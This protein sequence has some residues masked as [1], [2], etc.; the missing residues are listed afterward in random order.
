[1]AVDNKAT[2]SQANKRPE[3]TSSERLY[4]AFKHG[5][6]DRLPMIDSYWSETIER[7]RSEGLPA[8]TSLED[9]RRQIE[10]NLFGVINLT[11]AAIPVLR[12]QGSGHI[13]QL[14]SVG[15]RVGA[16]QLERRVA[17]EGERP[18]RALVGPGQ[19]RLLAQALLLEQR[20]RQ[21]EILAVPQ[22]AALEPRDLWHTP[23]TFVLVAGLLSAEW[24]LRRRWGLR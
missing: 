1:M 21:Q 4:T 19:L 7:W 16:R 6:P 10:T 14:S 23:V 9:F 11:K 17:P 5:I 20:V 2:D 18:R 3:M 13:I 15:G 24:I 22:G 12:G 8:D